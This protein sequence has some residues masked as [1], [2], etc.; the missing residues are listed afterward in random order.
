MDEFAIIA[1]LFAPLAGEGAFGLRDDAAV[2]AAR[3]GFDLVVTT[4]SVTEGTDFFAFDP[5]GT[6]AQKA[7]RVNLSDLAAKGAAPFGY[8]L[9]LALPPSITP[10]WLSAFARGL[11]Q[12]QGEFALS[13]LG[14]DTGRGEGPLSIAITAFGFVPQ[15]QM[16]RRSGARPGDDVYVTG[17][18]GDSGGGLAIFK[19]EKH[20]LPEEQRDVLTARY[21]VPRPPVAVGPRLREFASATIDVSDGLVADLAHV[22]RASKVKLTLDA[23]AIPRSPALRAFWGDGAE[24]II[25]AATAGDDYQIAF[26]AAPARRDAVMMAARDVGVTAA[27]IGRVE[28]GEGVELMLEGRVLAVPLPGYRHF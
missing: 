17:S 23:A 2:I 19:R 20:A 11:A 8:L 24:A 9:N 6:V 12:D 22:A 28:A 26:T 25:R 10:D 13:L 27:R 3:P 18:I 4:D 16:L 7:L 1:E 21:R 5:A 15:G 14:G